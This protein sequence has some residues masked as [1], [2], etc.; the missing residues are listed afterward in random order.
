LIEIYIE[1][2][3]TLLSPDGRQHILEPDGDGM[4]LAPIL[5]LR[6]QIVRE[7]MASSSGDLALDFA[8]GSRIRVSAS[9]RYEAWSIVGAG[10]SLISL[11]GGGLG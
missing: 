9:E 11:P 5:A 4:D 10:F 8:N 7:G 1:Q 6:R 3:F 2:P